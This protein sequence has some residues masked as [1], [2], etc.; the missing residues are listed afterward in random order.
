MDE[1]VHCIY[2]SCICEGMFFKQKTKKK[3]TNKFYNHEN[4]FCFKKNFNKAK[5]LLNSHDFLVYP[6]KYLYFEMQFPITHY[7]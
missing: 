1:S 4:I 3:K 2:G 6:Q 7:I 5:Y